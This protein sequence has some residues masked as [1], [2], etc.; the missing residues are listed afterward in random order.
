MVATLFLSILVSFFSLCLSSGCESDHAQCSF[1]SRCC[2]RYKNGVR[3]D[4]VCVNCTYCQ[5]TF[6]LTFSDCSP[7]ETRETSPDACTTKC[8]DYRD[9]KTWYVCRNNSCHKTKK[10]N[11]TVSRMAWFGWSIVI[12][13]G[14]VCPLFLVCGTVLRILQEK[15]RESRQ[16]GREASSRND[17]TNANCEALYTGGSNEGIY[18]QQNS[19]IFLSMEPQIVPNGEYSS[20]ANSISMMSLYRDPPPCYSEVCDM[21][22]EEPPPSYEVTTMGYSEK[23]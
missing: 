4:G 23:E 7:Q 18:P 21:P 10:D 5:Q 11:G 16:N 22:A 12:A 9:C 14:V 8:L 13:V 1:N 17:S 20:S 15:W 19:M 3:I 2:A 6:C